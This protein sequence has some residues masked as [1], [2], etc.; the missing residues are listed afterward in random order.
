M[1]RLLHRDRLVTAAWPGAW[2]RRRRRR[3]RRH[4]PARRAPASCTSAGRCATAAPSPPPGVAWRARALPPA[5]ACSASR[6]PTPGA[7]AGR[8]GAGR[9]PTRPRRPFAARR[10]VVGH[11]DTGRLPAAD[12]DRDAR[13]SRPTRRRSP[14]VSSRASAT[15]LACDPVRPYARRAGALERVHERHAGARAPASA[16]STSP[17][18]RRTT[19]SGDGAPGGQLP[20]RRRR[21]WRPLPPRG[22]STPARCG[23]AGTACRCAPPNTAGASLRSFHWRVVPLPAPA[24][25][26]PRHG[27][28]LL[29]SAPPRPHRPADALGLADRPRDPARAHWS[30]RPST[31]TTSTGS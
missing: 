20:R 6:W 26:V 12:R 5:T 21:G 22:W 3:R 30:A 29:V 1:R 2:H 18:R 8:D 24:A 17:S 25:C 14:S 13:S 19:D 9:R 4:R 31:S 11:A 23:R 28:G 10:Y 15:V 7:R 16:R 27:R